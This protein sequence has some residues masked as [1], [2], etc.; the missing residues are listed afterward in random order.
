[1]K[2]AVII[3]HPLEHSLTCAVADAYAS[4]VR[5]LGHQALVRDLYRMGFDPC[6]KPSEVPQP[7][8]VHFHADVAAERNLLGDVD[9]F[10]FVYPLWFN[11]PPAILKGYVERVFGM[12]FGYEGGAAG[13][14]SLLD[15]KS[16][17]S[18]TSSGAPDHWVQ[19]TGALTALETL[20]DRHL[21][22]MCGLGV[23]DHV[24][25]GGVVHDLNEVAF[26]AILAKVER[27]VEAHFGG[28]T[29]AA[30]ADLRNN[31]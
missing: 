29:R 27:A 19:D 18:F 1:M 17:I 3:A 11:S 14:E 4:R 30:K 12:G 20:F 21:A 6:L 7:S 13:A 31:P 5:E 16:M 28:R 26:A 15:G 22:Q 9:V 25:T 24:H 23:I 2:H 8:G 10:A